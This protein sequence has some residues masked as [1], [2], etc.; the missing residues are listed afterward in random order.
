MYVSSIC[1]VVLESRVSAGPPERE[2]APTFAGLSVADVVFSLPLG[3]KMVWIH[4]GDTGSVGARRQKF[5][6][7]LQ[8]RTP[9]KSAR[10]SGASTCLR[11]NN[12]F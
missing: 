7:T 10:K 2:N 5:S 3:G 11:Q 6:L 4:A 8:T 9:L 1:L 12:N